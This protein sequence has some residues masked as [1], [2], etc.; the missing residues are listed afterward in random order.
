M[1]CHVLNLLQIPASHLIPLHIH[2]H[3][4]ENL[5]KNCLI[6][7]KKPTSKSELNFYNK[8]LEGRTQ[9]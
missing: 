3:L 8:R 9:K 1:L 2:Q 6:H 7:Q 4:K 5:K